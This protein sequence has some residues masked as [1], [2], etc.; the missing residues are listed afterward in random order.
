M[1]LNEPIDFLILVF[2]GLMAGAINT[3]G[4]GG[5]LLTLPALIFLGLPPSIANA[6]NR[7]GIL[8]SSI[9]ATTGY[10]S[11]GVMNFPF[12]IYLGFSALFGSLLG[13]KIAIEIDGQL[14]NKILS[15]LMIIVLLLIVFKPSNIQ[16]NFVEKLHGKHLLI[17]ILI[18]FL[19]GIYGGFINAGIGI[20]IMFF[21]NSFNNLSLV[22]SN[23]TKVSVVSIYTFA[24]VLFFAYN[25]KIDWEA[26][27]VLATGTSVG[28]WLASRWSVLKGDKTIKIFLI[29]CVSV[30]SIKLWF[31]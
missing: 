5:S 6:S 29:I 24:A 10:A 17:S 16:N 11:K 9:S 7:I 22:K 20:I 15:I 4:G 1:Y 19:I 3:L 31:F 2:V 23:A 30:M 13:A 12:N 28:A 18:F 27:F 21:L 14:F 26:G 25:N 8:F